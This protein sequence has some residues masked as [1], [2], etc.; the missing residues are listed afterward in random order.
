MNAIKTRGS[1]ARVA[2]TTKVNYDSE[3]IP[4]HAVSK[5]FYSDAHSLR[6]TIQ[7]T[8]ERVSLLETVAGAMDIQSLGFHSKSI[9]TV[10][11]ALN[12]Q[13]K[14]DSIV[15]KLAHGRGELGVTQNLLIRSVR[16]LKVTMEN[17][18]AADSTVRE[19]N[20]TKKIATLMQNRFHANTS[21]AK[22]E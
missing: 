3:N 1:V 22:K 19:T 20:F 13:E 9:S 11:N 17:L 8:S 14:I 21:T 2:N 15:K 12:A 10:K 7:N 4:N 16:T 6:Q 5:S 18:R